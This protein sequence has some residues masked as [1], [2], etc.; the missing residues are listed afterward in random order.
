MLFF[1]ANRGRGGGCDPPTQALFAM[2]VDS[3]GR[4]CLKL[5]MPIWSCFQTLKREI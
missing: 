3:G 1:V 2:L 5:A 4:A